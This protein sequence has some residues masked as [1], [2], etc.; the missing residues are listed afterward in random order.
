M[1]GREHDGDRE[2]VSEH[3]S[4]GRRYRVREFTPGGVT[5][6]R[7]EHDGWELLDDDAAAAVLARLR[8]APPVVP[9]NLDGPID[10]AFAEPRGGRTYRSPV[11][12]CPTR[13]AAQLYVD[14]V[15]DL[16]GPEAAAARRWTF[17]ASEPSE[18]GA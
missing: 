13:A 15:H 9:A 14:G 11:E 2:R 6:E 4:A 3:T 12:R 1:T 17:R 7:A 18:G 10:V 16:L 8:G 5:V